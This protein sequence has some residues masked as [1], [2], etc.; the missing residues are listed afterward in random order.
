MSRNNYLDQDGQPTLITCINWIPRLVEAQIKK[1]PDQPS[2]FNLSDLF[3]DPES[4][5]WDRRSNHQRGYEWR[6]IL[7]ILYPGWEDYASGF[8][9]LG[10]LFGSENNE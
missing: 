6:A 7:M 1:L 8:E 5:D 10:S 9:G 4:K 2:E 3:G